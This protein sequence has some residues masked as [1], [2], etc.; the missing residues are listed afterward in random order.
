MMG[1]SPNWGWYIVWYFFIGGIAGGA[2]FAAAIADLFGKERGWEV[3]KVGYYVALPLVLLC[4]I[5][6]TLDLGVPARA[7]N[8]FRTFDIRS[9]MSVGSWALLGFGLFTAFS[10]IA[11][12][13]EDRGWRGL[14]FPRRV[15]GVVG[16]LFGFFIASY[17]GVL[18]Q[19]TNRPFWAGSPLVGA[20]FLVSGASTGLAAIGLLLS[21][22]KGELQQ[23]WAKLEKADGM[24]LAFEALVLIAFLVSVGPLSASLLQGPFALPFWGGLV[25]L[26]LLAPF[27]LHLVSWIRGMRA[28]GIYAISSVCVLVGGFALR[29]VILMAGQA[30]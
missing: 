26:G 6:L 19:A 29:Y 23:T 28:Y 27:V 16:A 13:L 7:F 8:M 11:A 25:V 17:T 2:Y 20:L 4:P 5:L 1:Q 3:A 12:F 10:A 24:A 15:V 30:L 9:P 21:F 22:R 14:A 18:L